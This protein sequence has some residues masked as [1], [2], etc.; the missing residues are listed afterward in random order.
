[1]HLGEGDPAVGRVPQYH[2]LARRRRVRA[3]RARPVPRVV[4]NLDDELGEA[5][6]AQVHVGSDE[7]AHARSGEEHG[8]ARGE[9]AATARDAHRPTY[10][11]DR[12]SVLVETR[13]ENN[14]RHHYQFFSPIPSLRPRPRSRNYLRF[15]VSGTASL[16]PY[17]R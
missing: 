10:G 15:N 16:K 5:G 11:Q 4:A 6:I 1:M 12:G 2:A 17:T 14:P 3:R 7:A 9:D 8:R 13:M